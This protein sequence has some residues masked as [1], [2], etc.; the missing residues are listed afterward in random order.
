MKKSVFLY[1]V[2]VIAILFTGCAKKPPENSAPP[3]SIALDMA[4][5]YNKMNKSVDMP[6]MLELD[7]TMKMDFCGVDASKCKQA[8]MYICEDSLRA[9]EIWLIEAND[10]AYLKEIETLLESRIKAKE[11][12]SITYSPE[13]H[14]IIQKHKVIRSGNCIVLIVSP[15]VDALAKAVQ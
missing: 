6:K 11:A 13:Q 9:D 3:A 8:Y 1:L 10:E 14:A 15:D 7:D 2:L 4:A 12:E 5:I